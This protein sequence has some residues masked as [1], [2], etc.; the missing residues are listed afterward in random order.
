MAHE[1]ITSK[2]ITISVGTIVLVIATVWSAFGLGRPIFASDLAEVEQRF[3]LEIMAVNRNVEALGKNTRIGLLK[4]EL[5]RLQGEMRQLHSE[6]RKYPDDEDLAADEE[7]LEAEIKDVQDDISCL[8][9]KD[10]V[11][12]DEF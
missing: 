12:E 5:S 4:L 3:N 2:T 8:R 9:S 6:M 7:D 10:C 1:R 11:L